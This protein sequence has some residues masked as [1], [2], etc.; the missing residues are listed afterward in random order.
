MKDIGA[1]CSLQSN[2]VLVVVGG[3]AILISTI[4]RIMRNTVQI[5]L[6]F[7]FHKYMK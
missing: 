1:D 5:V 3:R 7:T 2:I 6:I 4:W